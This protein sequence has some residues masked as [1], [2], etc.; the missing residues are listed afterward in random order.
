M[1][2]F[3]LVI[4]HPVFIPRAYPD[5][6]ERFHCTWGGGFAVLLAPVGIVQLTENYNDLLDFSRGYPQLMILGVFMI[7]IG[8]TTDSF[9]SRFGLTTLKI[10]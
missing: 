5:K 10:V 1:Y 7:V 4:A 3:P 6:S 2:P 9:I 8:A